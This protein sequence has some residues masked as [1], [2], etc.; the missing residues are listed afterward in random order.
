MIEANR[1]V[2]VAYA[3]G[4]AAGLAIL[5]TLT[6]S[7]ELAQWPQLH[8]ARGGLLAQAGRADE[9]AAAYRDALALEP[10]AATRQFLIERLATLR[11]S[12]LPTEDT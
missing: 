12:A 3:E 5:D 11:A 2:A 7:P 9:A 10:P 1:A 4:T 6:A 8:V